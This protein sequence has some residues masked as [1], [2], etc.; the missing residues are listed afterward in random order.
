MNW[1][2]DSDKNIKTAKGKVYNN[3][4]ASNNILSQKRISIKK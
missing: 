1:L 2:N 4:K 3:I